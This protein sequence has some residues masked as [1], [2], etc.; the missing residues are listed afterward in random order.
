ME[1]VQASRPHYERQGMVATKRSSPKTRRPRPNAAAARKP[2][3]L[4]KGL[5]LAILVPGFLGSLVLLGD[6]AEKQIHNRPRYRIAFTD[7]SCT[8]PANMIRSDFL[9]EV[10]YHAE[11]PDQFNILD[12]DLPKLLARAFARHPWVEKVTRVRI[13]SPRSVQVECVYRTPVLAV[14]WGDR[15][16]AVDRDGILLPPNALTRG[17]PLYKGTAKAPAGPNGTKWGDPKVEAAARM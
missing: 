4:F 3:L 10:Q 15:I 5:V 16:R 11:L 6:Y 12:D 7:I 8:P 2:G 9:S 14:R 1:S 17:L 13:V